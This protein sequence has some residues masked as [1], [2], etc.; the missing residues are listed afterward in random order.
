MER[1]TVWEAEALK[2]WKEQIM[3]LSEWLKTDE[4]KTAPAIVQRAVQWRMIELFPEIAALTKKARERG[5][6]GKG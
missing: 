4:G 5:G 2:D 6:G 3:V 1:L